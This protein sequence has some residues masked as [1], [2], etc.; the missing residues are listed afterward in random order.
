M[1]NYCSDFASLVG[2]AIGITSSAI[3]LNICTITAGIKKYEYENDKSMITQ[4]C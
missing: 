3:E 2:I 1:C 4:Y